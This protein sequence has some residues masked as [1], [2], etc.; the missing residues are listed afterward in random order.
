[1]SSPWISPTWVQA[2]A[3]VRVRVRVKVRVRVV[4]R[5][6]AHPDPAG[7]EWVELGPRAHELLGGVRVELVVEGLLREGEV[8]ED[9]LVTVRVTVSVRVKARVRVRVRVRVRA[10][11]RVR[12]RVKVRVRVRVSSRG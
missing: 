10:R 4:G 6:R 2:K 8:L 12:V 11:V 1:M 9:D 3:R 7:G 5:V